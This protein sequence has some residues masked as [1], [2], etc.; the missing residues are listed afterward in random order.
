MNARKRQPV[1]RLERDSLVSWAVVL[2]IGTVSQT[3]AAQTAPASG[4]AALETITVTATRREESLQSVPISITALS[5]EALAGAGVTETRDLVGLTPN[6]AQQGSFGRTSPSFFIRGVG[7]TQFN[8]N[9]NSKV[10]V[11]LDD[12]YLSS[13]AVHGSQIFDVTSVEIARGPQG[14]LFGQNTT[15]G[16]V[17]L[18]TT[19]PSVAGGFSMD[20]SLTA[21]R[22]GQLDPELAVGFE[23]GGSSAARFSVLQQKRDGFQ[24]NRLLGS[25]DGEIDALGWRAQWLWQA[26]DEVDLLV[27]V[28]GS[29]DSGQLVPYK[30]V[31]LVDP[32]TSGPCTNPGLGTGC[33]DFFG[34]ADTK[35]FHEG[36]WDV[37]DQYTD[38]ESFGAN[39]TLDWKLPAFTLTSVT[40]WEQNES[41]V[42]EDP[43]ASPN[44]VMTGNYHGEPQQT[45]Q[46]IR[47][48]S[49]AGGLSWIAGAYY[50]HETND[51]SVGFP[52]PGFGPG[53][54]SG[55]T[56]VL[57]GLGQISS[58]E[59]DSYA[60]FGN[61]DL[62]A[63]DK[64][65]LTV[66][67]RYTHETKDVDYGAWLADVT[68]VANTTFFTGRQ[69]TDRAIAQ[70]I[71]FHE[72][73][74]WDDVSGRVSL[75][76]SFND[77]VLGYATI[78]RGFNSG[79]YN[80]GALSDPAEAALV[81]PETLMSYE[82]GLKSEPS[83]QLRLNLSAFYYD[84]TD[85]QVFILA[86]G[87]SGVP[88]QQLSN[89]A[90]STLY[91]LELEAVWRPVGPLQLQVGAGYT[92][93]EFDE[94]K[95]PLGQDLSGGTLPTAPETNVNAMA[96]YAI[97]TSVGTWRLEADAKYQSKQY[98]SVNND[99]ILSQGAHTVANAHVSWT[100][101]DEHVTVTT[102]V[103]NLADEDYLV[104]AFD[105]ASFG[106]NQWVVG[107]PR[108]YG[109]TLEY[110][111]H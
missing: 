81:D 77:D 64:L 79:N 108:T 36:Q 4:E 89:A 12:V 32:V 100:S 34:Y 16:L 94:F 45:S 57:E 84:F 43:D 80:G 20:A 53:A 24:R 55:L 41:R 70:T 21:G 60:V 30:Q 72:K 44:Y 40:A 109:M 58:M 25:D 6:L 18:I 102:W 62:A 48:T 8:P 11:Y 87:D 86:A 9:A 50:F 78:A 90:A 93:S 96:T 26:S 91:G 65:K 83:D 67:L 82:I 31:G 105:L 103:R 92:H 101:R 35:D 46:E 3:T 5:G 38:V 1:S 47:L 17:R 61:V 106:W 7:S 104:G 2:A 68:D 59:T 51:T 73:E 52:I 49:P 15:G 111:T 19:R 22:Y 56:D 99:P 42:H 66:G 29:R 85:Q 69:I 97:P 23:T 71:D 74:S 75:A 76:Y 107:E 28:H 37:P 10:G 88:V 98:F 54:L 33:T 63:T 39:L 110:H 14:T 27:R 13:P 95:T